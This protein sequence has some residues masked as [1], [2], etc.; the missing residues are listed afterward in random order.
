MPLLS[1]SDVFLH[2]GVNLDEHGEARLT[3]AQ[4]LISSWLRRPLDSAERTETLSLH[5]DLTARTVGLLYPAATP[6]TAVSSPSTVAIRTTAVLEVQ[7]LPAS[8]W[9]DP[10]TTVE[11]TYTGGW[12]AD[13]LPEDLVAAIA[14]LAVSMGAGLGEV[15]DGSAP[16]PSS[17]QSVSLDGAAVS[18]GGSSGT[19]VR[20]SAAAA[21]ERIAADHNLGRWRR[22]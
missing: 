15:L 16:L 9:P 11:V 17:V 5:R 6:V 4:R 19:A 14:N 18:F 7:S 21:V 8:T 12:T 10:V 3:R 1:D 22:R 20:E 2:T 13:T